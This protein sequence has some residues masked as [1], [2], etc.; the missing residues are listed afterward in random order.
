M[1]VNY[2]FTPE[3]LG[4]SVDDL[5]RR[6]VIGESGLSKMRD[7]LIEQGFLKRDFKPS[8]VPVKDIMAANGR[9]YSFEGE[10]EPWVPSRIEY[11]HDH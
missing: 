1:I 9:Y 3:S 11:L 4:R 7:Q 10:I 2:S 6:K 5:I 8:I